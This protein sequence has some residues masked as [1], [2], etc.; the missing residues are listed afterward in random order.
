MGV[1]IGFIF[2]GLLL[3]IGGIILHFNKLNQILDNSTKINACYLNYQGAI[4]YYYDQGGESDT[5]KKLSANP[6]DFKPVE[7]PIISRTNYI[8]CV[9]KDK[10]NVYFEG[11]VIAQANPETFVV[12]HVD[13][14]GDFIAHDKTNAFYNKK[15]LKNASIKSVNPI[16][17]DNF[18]YIRDLKNIYYH[19]ELVDGL[20]SSG[21]K[22]IYNKSGN[23]EYFY[24]GDTTTNKVYFQG[25]ITSIDLASFKLFNLHGIDKNFVYYKGRP[26]QLLNSKFTTSVT[27][28]EIIKDDKTVIYLS[29]E[30]VILQTID[31]TKFHQY[32]PSEVSQMG[33][34]KYTMV[35]GDG[36]YFYY[37]NTGSK[38][39]EIS[40]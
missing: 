23:V 2:L 22:Y 6:T 25:N 37:C 7:L 38:I 40:K 1:Y 29:D 19:G 3:A 32:S 26:I 33:I 13:N 31:A 15:I 8:P 12:T 10:S 35:C 5:Y 21:F 16:S 17:Q 30:P 28:R 11:D 18:I 20:N 34:S 14:T 4:Y 36:T 24:A 27:D 9:G 39:T